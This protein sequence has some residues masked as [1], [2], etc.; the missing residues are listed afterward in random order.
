MTSQNP[1]ILFI[2]WFHKHEINWLFSQKSYSVK[3]R[4]SVIVQYA[5]PLLFRSR[6]P[7][8]NESEF[9]TNH[10]PVFSD[11]K[12]NGKVCYIT[13]KKRN[14]I[15]ILLQCTVKCISSLLSR[16]WMIQN[17]AWQKFLWKETLYDVN[18]VIF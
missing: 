4:K 5:E 17:M 8:Q 16:L 10:I 15:L 13:I 3:W 14:E 18:Y 9:Q 11:T 2:K 12:K 7:H 6:P 1:V